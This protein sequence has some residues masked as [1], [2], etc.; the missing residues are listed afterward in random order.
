VAEGGDPS[1]G[2]G[3]SSQGMARDRCVGQA[4]SDAQTRGSPRRL[5]SHPAPETGCSHVSPC[6]VL[7]S[8]GA[9]CPVASLHGR[10]TIAQ[11]W[12]W[13]FLLPKRGTYFEKQT[14]SFVAHW[15]VTKHF[16]TFE[17]VG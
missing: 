9:R 17:K 4:G 7:S 11:V 16:L 8:R 5:R 1:R 10:A 12:L 15:T 6:I 3:A 14:E 13:G 2:R